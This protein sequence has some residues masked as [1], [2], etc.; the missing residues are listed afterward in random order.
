M[1]APVALYDIVLQTLASTPRHAPDGRPVT[2]QSWNRAIAAAVEARVAAIGDITLSAPPLLPI[3]VADPHV[4][5]GDAYLSACADALNLRVDQLVGT[6]GDAPT[7]S[8]RQ[9]TAMTIREITG[10]SWPKLAQLLGY[11]HHAA[12]LSGTRRAKTMIARD[13]WWADRYDACLIACRA[14][15]APAAAA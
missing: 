15:P 2:A 1:T 7:V 13:T 4:I 11:R 14:K 8:A 9:I 3:K 10:M 5:R 12:V 6:Y